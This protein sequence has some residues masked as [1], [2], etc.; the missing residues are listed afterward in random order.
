MV[1]KP[2]PSN[3]RDTDDGGGG[4]VTL[5]YSVCTMQPLIAIAIVQVQVDYMGWSPYTAYSRC[6]AREIYI[7]L[8]CAANIHTWLARAN[9]AI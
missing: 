2:T 5:Q 9:E 4:G 7:Y 3:Q 1:T 8:I 6:R